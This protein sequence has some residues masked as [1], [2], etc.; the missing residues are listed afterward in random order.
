MRHLPLKKPKHYWLAGGG[1][2][3][4]I[5]IG[6][7]YF[8]LHQDYQSRSGR[9][10]PGFYLGTYDLSGLD[11][12]AALALIS[13]KIDRFKE[14]GLDFQYE[15]KKINLGPALSAGP[16]NF[17]ADIFSLDPAEN[18]ERVFRA[19]GDNFGAYLNYRWQKL[20][21][22]QRLDFAYQLD[23]DNLRQILKDSFGA[24]E[25]PAVNAGFRLK[26]A[27]PLI[28]EIRPE[29][30]GKSFD[31]ELALAETRNEL[32]RLASFPI[33]LKSKTEYPKVYQ[34][35]LPGLEAKAKTFL[36]QHELKLSYNDQS[37]TVAAAEIAAWLMAAPA[38]GD[39]RLDFDQTQIK[40]Y[41][42]NKIALQIDQEAV[43][44]RF[45]MKGSQLANWQT[46]ADG[47]KLN[48]EASV[49]SIYNNLNSNS[50]ETVVLTVDP[51]KTDSLSPSNEFNIKE[52]I[53][54][55]H[56]NFAGSPANRRHNIAVGAAAVNGLL[57]KP[58]E[59]FSLVKTLGAVE[60][61]TGYLPELVIKNNRTIPEYG[62]G[63]CQIGTTVFRAAIQSGLPITERRNHSYR[64]SYYEPA[65]MDAAIYIPKPDVRFL[66]D[67]SNYILIQSR[68]I[69]N[70]IYFDFWGVKDGREISISKPT[71]YNIVKPAP[72]KIVE[73]PDLK[74]GEKKC[75]EKAHNGA[76]A[77]FD[78]QVTYPPTASST[79]SAIKQ[80]R[81]SSHYVPWQEVCLVGATASSS[82]TTT[83]TSTTPIATSTTSNG[84]STNQNNN[85]VSSSTTINSSTP[86][87]LGTP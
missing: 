29:R 69:K 56:S 61:S 6:A 58:G 18:L 3:I 35:D 48:L 72:T 67:T 46:G 44:P 55:G 52:I 19:Q 74:P 41:L 32:S 47:R 63:L 16:D 77:Y 75:T 80:V 31:Y 84:T 49:Q 7:G 14:S 8:Y 25:I 73:S 83:A 71:V 12:K 20:F 23:E 78:Y 45:S 70:D 59:E 53:G 27:E 37:W 62:G 57:I 42:E 76:D 26:S 11:K 2:V 17:A 21:R 39:L 68:I 79:E 4:L 64:V 1:L 33:T 10:Y 43:L 50:N 82:A 13:D 28:L 54:T 85:P 51:V 86:L 9:I 87:T 36:D 5:L 65:G 15:N 38:N 40:S 34:K 30:S 66:N 81:F 60:S 22:N 24:Q